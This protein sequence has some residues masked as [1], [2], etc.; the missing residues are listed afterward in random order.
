[1]KETMRI[2]LAGVRGTVPMHTPATTRYG[3]ATTCVLVQAGEE[4]FILDAGTGLRGELFRAFAKKPQFTMLLSHAHVDHLMGFPIFP[5]LF[6]RAVSG[7]IYLATRGGRD[8]RAQIEALMAPPLWP[9]RTDAVAASLAFHDVPPAFS[10]GDVDISTLAVSHPGGC[11]AYR[12]TRGAVS[13][14][15]AT[16]F[17]ADGRDNADFLAFARDCSL[18]LLD[19]QYSAEEYAR[20]RGFGHSTLDAAVALAADCGAKQTIFIHHDP[21]RTDDVLDAWDTALRSAHPT[22]HLGRGGEEVIL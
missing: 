16:D 7:D 8:A 17:E 18:L 11:T 1:M 3:G 22:M 10:V 5:P 12:L 6:D 13:L 9:I 2:H 14:V 21:N 20:T 15:Y 19:A 4:T